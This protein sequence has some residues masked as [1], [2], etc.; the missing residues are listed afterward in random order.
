MNR[1]EKANEC[2][3][4]LSRHAKNNMKLYKIAEQD[5]IEIIESPE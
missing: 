1:L 5:I 3:M 4:K 2:P